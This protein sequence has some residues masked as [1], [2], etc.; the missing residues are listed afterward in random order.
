M[1]DKTGDGGESSGRRLKIERLV[2]EYD[3]RGLG[4]DLEHQYTSEGQSRSSLRDLADHVNRELLRTALEETDID[5]LPGEAANYYRLL[6]GEDVTSG[7]RTEARARLDRAGVDIEALESDFVTYQAVRSYLRRVRGV[8]YDGDTTSDSD[9]DL[10][11][12][13]RLRGRTA[14]VTESKLG[15]LRDAGTLTLGRFS[16]IVDVTVVCE[17]CGHQFAVDELLERG[18]CACTN[19]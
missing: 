14:A 13:D 11:I 1:P 15:Q 10:D 16:T 17:D 5:L 18:G 12:V 2:E 4:A 19:I 3:L 7:Q 6:T 9:P 8:Y